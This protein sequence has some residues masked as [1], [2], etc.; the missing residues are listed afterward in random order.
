MLDSLI[1]ALRTNIYFILCVLFAT[2]Y[3]VKNRLLESQVSFWEDCHTRKQ[4]GNSYPNLLLQLTTNYYK[5]GAGEQKNVV[6]CSWIIT[7]V[8]LC[9]KCE[10]A[11][12]INKW[13]CLSCMSI[14]AVFFQLKCYPDLCKKKKE[15]L[16]LYFMP[17]SLSFDSPAFLYQ[18]YRDTSKQQEIEQRRQRENLSPGVSPG[19]VVE[20]SGVMSPPV[21]QLQLRNNARS[22]SLWQNL[23]VV[24]A[25]GL[26]SQ[27]PQSEI[28]IQEVSNLL[29][30]KASID[31]QKLVI[32]YSIQVYM[33]SAAEAVIRMPLL[34]QIFRQKPNC[35][36]HSIFDLMFVMGSPQLLQSILYMNVWT[37]LHLMVVK[38]F[39]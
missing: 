37:I 13:N 32:Q 16:Y 24:Q 12:H 23:E 27:L 31:I 17:D 19:T 1:W 8:K 30:V 34:W 36:T 39:T 22:L 35:W 11:H 5:Q 33:C 4:Q 20:G 18:E 7:C 2:D 29:L 15:S 14:V 25:S 38:I 26:L 6:V 3:L 9:G 10:I 21:L 28:I